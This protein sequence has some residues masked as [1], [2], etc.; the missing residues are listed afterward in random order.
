MG[1]L[2]DSFLYV[3]D[4]VL[5]ITTLFSGNT[6]DQ[7]PKT[8]SGNCVV[9]TQHW[10]GRGDKEGKSA[11]WQSQE[12]ESQTMCSWNQK[13]HE[14]GV[15]SLYEFTASHFCQFQKRMRWILGSHWAASLRGRK[16]KWQVTTVEVNRYFFPL[17]LEITT[18]RIRRESSK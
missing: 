13:G 3:T 8:V 5:T 2:E 1:V 14:K 10:Q 17:G 4:I 12:G 7:E 9:T 16:E 6:T 18:S 15:D 11:V